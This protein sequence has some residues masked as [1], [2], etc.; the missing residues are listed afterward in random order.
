MTP[1]ELQQCLEE[2]FGD[3]E[4]P[5]FEELGF[6]YPGEKFQR[7]VKTDT[8]R[9]KRWQ[10]LRPLSEYVLGALDII[11]LAPKACQ[12]YLPAYLYAMTDPAVVWCYLSPVVEIL[13]YEH[14]HGDLRFNLPYYRDKWERLA[15][16]LTDRQKRCIAHFL[17][18]ILK[19][20]NDP[21]V[22]VSASVGWEADQ[23]ER[24]LERYWNAWL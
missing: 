6:F 21:S 14:D 20:I 1:K 24:M 4:P 22:E 16:L 12:Y 18:E 15:A 3:L 13:W 8:A 9:T 11:A 2:A 19:S 23:I 17:V 10:E 5:Y 7:V